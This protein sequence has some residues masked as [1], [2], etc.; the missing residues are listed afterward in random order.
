MVAFA[1]VRQYVYA[2][3][4][5]VVLNNKFTSKMSFAAVEGAPFQWETTLPEPVVLDKEQG[6]IS[7]IRFTLTLADATTKNDY[8]LMLDFEISVELQHS[9]GTWTTI[10]TPRIVTAADS[11]AF[12]RQHK[13]IDGKQSVSLEMKLLGRTPPA[14]NKKRE[15]RI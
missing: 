5:D 11:P 14:T 7:A 10:A 2:L 4:V 6:E 3:D 15:P 9:N 1:D 8:G 13:N 12:L